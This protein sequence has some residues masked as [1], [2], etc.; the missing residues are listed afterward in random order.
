MFVVFFAG[1]DQCTSNFSLF[2]G[3]ERFAGNELTHEIPLVGPGIPYLGVPFFE[4]TLLRVASTG[5]QE[6]DHHF[7]WPPHKRRAGPL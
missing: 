5:S 4:D 2:P 3:G 6:E 1:V 7:R